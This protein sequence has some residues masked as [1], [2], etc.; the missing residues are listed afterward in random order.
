VPAE[1]DRLEDDQR[2][3]GEMS[4][5]YSDETDRQPDAEGVDAESESEFSRDALYE[6]FMDDQSYEEEVEDPAEE[7]VADPIEEEPKAPA[8][9]TTPPEDDEEPAAIL[10]EEEPEHEP[11]DLSLRIPNR[12]WSRLSPEARKAIEGLREN[13]KRTNDELEGQKP[14]ADYGRNILEFAKHQNMQGESFQAWLDIGAVVNRGGQGAVD[15]CLEMARALGWN[16]KVPEAPKPELPKALQQRVD[17]LILTEEEAHEIYAE[18]LPQLLAQPQ[19]PQEQPAPANPDDL[20]IREGGKQLDTRYESAEKKYGSQWE[21][22]VKPAVEREMLKHKGTDPRAWGV[23]FDTSLE[24]VLERGRRRK[25]PTQEKLASSRSAGEP[26]SR[27]KKTTGRD[28]LYS[29]FGRS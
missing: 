3:D 1:Q 2:L 5:T 6:R 14:L 22:R 19:A 10:D 15:K 13:S 9:E 25:R 16:G 17:D 26:A 4:E 8:A 21:T 27:G 7:Q 20:A 28:R 24:L 29:E 11:E 23:L 12:D 18:A